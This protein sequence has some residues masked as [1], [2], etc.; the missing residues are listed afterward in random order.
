MILG[1]ASGQERA[2]KV[3][4]ADLD[5]IKERLGA[6]EQSVNVVSRF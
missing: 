2:I 6:F 5:I 1:I 4:K 3:M